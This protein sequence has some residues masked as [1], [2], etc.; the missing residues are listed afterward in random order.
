M[1][2]LIAI[3][4]PPLYFILKKKWLAFIGSMIAFFFAVIF[5]IMIVLLPLSFILWALCSVIAVWD[6]RKRL[7]HEHADVLATKMAEKMR[8]AQ[9]TPPML[10]KK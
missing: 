4:I 10:I 9:T 7:M 1:I 6:L 8:E 3:F 2:Y 5:A